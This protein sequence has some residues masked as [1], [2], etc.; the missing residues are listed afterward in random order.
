MIAAGLILQFIGLLFCFTIIGAVIGIPLII[1]GGILF[2]V[3]LF[4]RRKTVITNVVTVQH[5][6]SPIAPAK[7]RP[8]SADEISEM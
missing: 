8:D 1:I 2:I 3:G 5:A 4:G 6:S 7:P